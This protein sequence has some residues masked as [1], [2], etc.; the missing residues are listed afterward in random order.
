M[1]E[2]WPKIPSKVA[3]SAHWEFL[4][5]QIRGSWGE[6]RSRLDFHFS[7]CSAQPQPAKRWPVQQV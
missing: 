3:A 6:G 7:A 2:E 5:L 4:L 1:A